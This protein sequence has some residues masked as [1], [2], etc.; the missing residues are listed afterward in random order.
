[1]SLENINEDFENEFGLEEAKAGNRSGGYEVYHSTYSS[2]VQTA[3][4]EA[5]KR[6]YS[7][8][9]DEWQRVVAS[10]PSK[11]SKDKTNRLSLSLMKDGKPSKKHLQMQVY[12]TGEKYE[13]NMYIESV[14]LDEL[15]SETLASYKKKA[16][17]DARKADASGDFK[18]GNKR[19]SGVVKATKK[20]FAKN[21]E[22]VT[23][24]EDNEDPGNSHIIMLLRK[25][26]SLR[27]MKPVKFGD[28]RQVKVSVSDAQ[29]ALSMFAGAKTPA[30]KSA[31]Q[32]KLGASYESLQKTINE[33]VDIDEG[34]DLEHPS[35]AWN[36]KTNRKVL[37]IKKHGA[38]DITGVD[39]E[40]TAMLYAIYGSRIVM[41]KDIKKVEAEANI[42]GYT[43]KM[44]GSLEEKTLTPD[45]I[46]K[47]EEIVKKLKGKDLDK[48][49]DTDDQDKAIAYATATK[50][51]K[52]VAEETEYS[53]LE[54]SNA[55]MIKTM[56]AAY[57]NIQGMDPSSEA[58]KKL[59]TL[60]DKQPK[61]VLKTLANANIKWVSSLARNRLMRE[62]V[63]LEEGLNLS[64]LKGMMSPELLTLLEI[65]KRTK[66]FQNGRT[67]DHDIQS[68]LDM[69]KKEHGTAFASRLLAAAREVAANSGVQHFALES[70]QV[71]DERVLN[72]QQRLAKARQMRKIEPKLQAKKKI[73]MSRMADREHLEN[74]ARKAAM[75]ALRKK[76]AGEKGLHYHELSP[77][78]KMSVDKRLEGKQ[79]LVGKIAQRLIAKIRKKEMDRVAALHQ[80]T[81]ESVISPLEEKAEKSGFSFDVLFEVYVRAI[82]EYNE[83]ALEEMYPGTDDQYAFDSVNS[84]ISG[85]ASRRLNEDLIR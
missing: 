80:K 29:K 50:I 23:E 81:N 32:K 45:E 60:L 70:V 8:D 1:M 71:I 55:T 84:F 79:A 35:S 44:H 34:F 36:S 43:L 2:A 33:D 63:D 83:N 62:D 61:D 28:G 7:I 13:L 16:G 24:E 37:K 3:A 27:G 67:R 47:K 18:R 10:G 12:N 26:V 75:N 78:E 11:P 46:K 76:F 4:K 72:I 25:A 48:D 68:Y 15:S 59:T 39:N 85:G 52:K 69:V 6:G 77:T 53:D 73:T 64:I 22:V 56:K 38:H 82:G 20:E 40:H 57:G 5:E 31:I 65:L 54:E 14:Q 74:R 41:I 42:H 21:E 17:E 19:F 66:D 30:E 9:D 51:A 49:S 58:Y